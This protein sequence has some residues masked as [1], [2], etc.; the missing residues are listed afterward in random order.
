M[1]K[2]ILLLSLSCL[3]VSCVSCV[4]PRN[5][6]ELKA[7]PDRFETFVV[8]ENYELAFQRAVESDF[9]GQTCGLAMTAPETVVMPESKKAM[10]KS[11]NTQAYEFIALDETTTRVDCYYGLAGLDAR[12]DD[13]VAMYKDVIV[14]P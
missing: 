2:F 4:G 1:K 9:G 7:K 5:Y 14:K 6:A 11:A 10:I 13:F 3:L 12:H 8:K